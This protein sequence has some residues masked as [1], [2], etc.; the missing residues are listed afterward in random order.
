VFNIRRDCDGFTRTYYS[1][2]SLTDSAIN[3]QP[4]EG[5]PPQIQQ[6]ISTEQ[7]LPPYNGYGT[8][9]DSIGSCKYL[10]PRPPKKDSTKILQDEHVVLRFVARLV[11][12]Y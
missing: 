2:A 10:V 4:V 9:E 12:L 1:E 11:L 7:P 6:P 8:I 5:I 3:P